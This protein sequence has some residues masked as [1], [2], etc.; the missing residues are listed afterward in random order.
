MLVAQFLDVSAIE[1]WKRWVSVNER[2]ELHAI[3]WSFEPYSILHTNVTIWVLW[4]CCEVGTVP[5]IDDLINVCLLIDST[6]LS[7][8]IY[9]VWSS[10]HSIDGF[11][12]FTNLFIEYWCSGVCNTEIIATVVL[13]SDDFCCNIVFISVNQIHGCVL[14]QSTTECVLLDMIA[15]YFHEI[16]S[17]IGDSCCNSIKRCLIISCISINQATGIVVIVQA[18]IFCGIGHYNCNGGCW[19]S[20][21]AGI[22]WRRADWGHITVV[23]WL[24]LDCWPLFSPPVLHRGGSLEVGFI[25][26]VNRI[27]SDSC[28]APL[29]SSNLTCGT[30]VS[31]GTLVQSRKRFGL[32]LQCISK[33]SLISGVKKFGCCSWVQTSGIL[34]ILQVCW[35]F[36]V[37][38]GID[39]EL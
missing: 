11:R 30:I 14:F 37:P 16:F 10:I 2:R 23:F 21:W 36:T 35:I 32:D 4:N 20:C 5:H 39:E 24:L 7:Y 26:L 1:D 31:V 19:K 15:H 29:E 28:W 9:T 8:F 25:I 17:R 34:Q 3:A 13:S 22:G 6:H 18:K 12:Y 33:A 27:K 38:S